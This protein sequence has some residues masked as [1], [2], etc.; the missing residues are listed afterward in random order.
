MKKILII[1][2]VIMALS[3]SGCANF[4]NSTALA[5]NKIANEKLSKSDSPIR[6]KAIESQ[7]GVSHK[8]YLIGKVTPSVASEMLKKDTLKL[9]MQKEGTKDIELIQ[10]RYVSQSANPTSFKEIWVV[11]INSDNALHGHTV[12]FTQSPN[13]GVD[14]LLIYSSRVFQSMLK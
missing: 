12:R 8:P 10:I 7:Y 5:G 2:S 9:I 13:G 1:G 4:G 6:Y 3:F 11:K 14:I